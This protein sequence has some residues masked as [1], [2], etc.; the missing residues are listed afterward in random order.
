METFCTKEMRDNNENFGIRYRSPFWVVLLTPN[1][2]KL[3]TRARL[4]TNQDHACTV[5]RLVNLTHFHNVAEVCSEKRHARQS[6]SLD[7]VSSGTGP[8][9]D[10]ILEIASQ[11]SIICQ[12]YSAVAS[13]IQYPSISQ[14][15]WL[16]GKR[17]SKGRSV[18]IG[19]DLLIT[20]F[21]TW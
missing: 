9:N 18:G 8:S 12:F 11:D 5:N 10:G 7:S 21:F 3:I 19:P 13:M 16:V 1:A 14:K 4:L 15:G 20:V 17:L 2:N 6:R